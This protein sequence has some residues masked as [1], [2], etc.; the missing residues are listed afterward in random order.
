MN[1]CAECSVRELAICRTLDENEID[2]FSANARRQQLRP[3]QVLQW[4]GDESLLVGNVIEGVVK[5]TATTRQG[6]DQTLG[7]AYAG[8]FIGRPFGSRNGQTVTALSEV[9]VCTFRREGFDAFARQHPDLEHD[10]LKRTLAELDQ[11][12]SWMVRLGQRDALQRV[13]GF[14][15]EMGARLTPKGAGGMRF[16]LP[17]GRQDIGDLLGLTI[18]TVSRQITALKQ[19]GVIRLPSQRE[20][21]VLDEEALQYAA[22]GE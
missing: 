10:L 12:R 2:Q 19:D 14:L 17:F 13:A 9:R 3:G 8:D 4:E 22:D 20:I 6:K 11:A 7:L 15:L 18:E 16:K 1:A 21:E 5:L